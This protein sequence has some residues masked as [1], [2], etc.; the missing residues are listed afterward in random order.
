[1]RVKCLAQEH[2]TMTRPGLDPGPL[3][4]ESSALTT[5]P[6][7]LPPSIP[8]YNK[9]CVPLF[10]QVSS[11]VP[12]TLG[13]ETAFYHGEPAATHAFVPCGHVCSEETVR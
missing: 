9:F 12:L 3:D 1:M 5:R 11:Y 2:N 4:P 13:K 7:R 8:R 6:P 10:Y